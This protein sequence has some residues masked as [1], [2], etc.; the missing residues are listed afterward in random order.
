[1]PATKIAQLKS[2]AIR[3]GFR[4]LGLLLLAEERTVGAEE[5]V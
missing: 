4:S 3:R 5:E 1:M 2:K